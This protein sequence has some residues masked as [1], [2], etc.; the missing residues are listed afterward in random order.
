MHHLTDSHCAYISTLFFLDVDECVELEGVCTN[1]GQCENTFGSY[2]CVCSHGYRGNG[3]HC[4]G[5]M[6]ISFI[7]LFIYSIQ[8]PYKYF[9]LWFWITFFLLP[10]LW[11]RESHAWCTVFADVNECISGLHNCNVNARCGNVVGSYFCQCH[12]GY[13]GDGHSCYGQSLLCFRVC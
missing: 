7:F 5:K 6:D 9:T 13:S 8:I 2:K 4:T 1:Q 12:Q 10:S 11:I 3:T